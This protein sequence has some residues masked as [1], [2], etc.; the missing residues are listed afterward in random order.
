MIIGI[1]NSVNKVPIR[2]TEER[3]I[4]IISSHK[5]VLRKDKSRVLNAV[6]K[7]D[8]ILQG[9]VGEILAIKKISGKSLWLVVV[10]KEVNR[11]DGFILTA[12]F[13]SDNRWLFKRKILWS[14]E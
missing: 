11:K 9:D 10:Y 12:Y 6:E 13:T 5:E 14:R 1:V 2:L 8:F 4:H 7:P 3:L